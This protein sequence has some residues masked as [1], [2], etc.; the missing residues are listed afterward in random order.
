MPNRIVWV[1]GNC[2]VF[3]Q[4]K[5]DKLRFSKGFLKNDI[6][7]GKMTLDEGAEGSCGYFLHSESNCCLTLVPVSYQLL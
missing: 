4:E 1:L 6:F 5:K 2:W 3:G 7:S